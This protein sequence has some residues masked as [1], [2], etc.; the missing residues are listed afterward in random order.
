MLE[1]EKALE[2]PLAKGKECDIDSDRLKTAAL[3]QID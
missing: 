2:G 3:I 1:P